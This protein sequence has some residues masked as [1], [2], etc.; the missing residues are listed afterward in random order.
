MFTVYTFLMVIVLLNIAIGI[1]GDTLERIQDQKET[2][3]LQI[4]A[5]L[6]QT[7][8]R[9]MPPSSQVV[10]LPASTTTCCY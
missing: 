2:L 6:I 3:T 9:S 8:Q 4:R 1:I 5:D 10:G 7:Y